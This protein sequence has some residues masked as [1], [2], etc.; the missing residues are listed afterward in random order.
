M[1]PN[2]GCLGYVGRKWIRRQ[3]WITLPT[4]YKYTETILF[5]S[6]N[7]TQNQMAENKN[8]LFT[9]LFVICM[10]VMLMQNANVAKANFADRVRECMPTCQEVP[11]STVSSC[12]QACQDFAGRSYDKQKSWYFCITM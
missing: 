9:N 2:I 3:W 12:E 11:G 4:C 5:L 1:P 6:K 7:F 10:L 8:F